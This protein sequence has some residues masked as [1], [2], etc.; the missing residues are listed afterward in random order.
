MPADWRERGY[1][2]SH[3]LVCPHC[4][5]YA[6]SINIHF[7]STKDSPD[8][9]PV[10]GW[11]EKAKHWR[12]TS[13]PNIHCPHC[14]SFIGY[15]DAFFSPKGGDPSFEGPG[16]DGEFDLLI[17]TPKRACTHQN[18]LVPFMDQRAESQAPPVLQA[19][20]HKTVCT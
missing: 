19:E 10:E 3:P 7:R 9:Q 11:G 14:G 15:I 4:G 16:E 13:R 8:V 5:E 17:S 20:R 2:G 6:G 1:S 12:T 18:T